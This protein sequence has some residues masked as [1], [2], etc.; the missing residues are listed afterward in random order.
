MDIEQQM[1]DELRTH[2]ALLKGVSR[3]Q[4]FAVVWLGVLIV[5]VA[6][7][8]IFGDRIANA[9]AARSAASDSWR[10]A[11]RLVDKGEQPKAREMIDRLIAK[12]PRND[13]G[14]RMLGFVEQEAGNIQAAET[15]FSRA[16]ELFPTEE[17]E[18]N[19][20]AIRKLNAATRVR[21]HD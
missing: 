19:L 21:G 4:A 17:N 18:K 1:L 16:C 12:N 14:Y 10:D 3:A 6:A 8:L 13:S 11:R 7:N 5:L 9:F 2:T 20:A 15:N